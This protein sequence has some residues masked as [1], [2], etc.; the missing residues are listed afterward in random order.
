VFNCEL[1]VRGVSKTVLGCGFTNP[2]LATSSL[3]PGTFCCSSGSASYEMAV[4]QS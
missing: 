1:Q 4:P 2:S 3:S